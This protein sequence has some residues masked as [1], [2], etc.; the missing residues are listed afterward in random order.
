MY[1]FLS[2]D[3][4]KT[5]VASNTDTFYTRHAI[6]EG[7]RDERNESVRKEKENM[8]IDLDSQ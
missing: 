2:H 3:H 5:P 6:F 4:W 8:H 1:D 7:L